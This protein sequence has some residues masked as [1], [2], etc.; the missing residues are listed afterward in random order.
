MWPDFE[1][2]SECLHL[3]GDAKPDMASL[4]LGSLNFPTGASVNAPDMIERLA[5]TMKD[6]GI[7]PELEAFDI[8]MIGYA[9]YLERKGILEGRKYFNLLLGSL[10]SAPATPGE[11]AAMVAALPD[12]STWS[13]AGIGMFQ[14]PMNTAAILAGGGVRVG[15]EDALHY[16]F[17]RTQLATN[18]QLVQRIARLAAELQRPLATAAEARDMIGTV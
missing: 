2:R 10:G 15:L 3:T 12:D 9:R 18:E 14:L 6:N 4:T 13:A 16:D 5:V 1:K 11:L 17:A 8:G 7:R